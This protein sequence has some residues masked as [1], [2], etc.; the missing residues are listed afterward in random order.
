MLSLNMHSIVI[1]IMVK[2]YYEYAI[3]IDA[4]REILSEEFLSLLDQ[5]S[6]LYNI[7]KENGI[8]EK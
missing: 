2:D 3:E 6:Y 4:I 1:I 8:G 5:D 7:F